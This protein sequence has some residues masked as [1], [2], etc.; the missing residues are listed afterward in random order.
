M[1]DESIAEDR[2][3]DLRYYITCFKTDITHRYHAARTVEDCRTND[4]LLN[5]NREISGSA[6]LLQTLGWEKIV[7]DCRNDAKCLGLNPEISGSALI[8]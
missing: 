1:I 8:L 2:R 7:E 3:H 5:S 6:G 4:K